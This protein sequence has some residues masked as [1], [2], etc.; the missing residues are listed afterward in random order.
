MT[1][2]NSDREMVELLLADGANPN[3]HVNSEG[4]AVYAARTTELRALLMARGGTLDLYD[5]VWLD[6]TTKSCG[7]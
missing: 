2:R 3:A 7:A 4:N 5:L 1:S 6:G